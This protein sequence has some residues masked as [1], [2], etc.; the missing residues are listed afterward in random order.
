MTVIGRLPIFANFA[1]TKRGFDICS[2]RRPTKIEYFFFNKYN[3][4]DIK[5]E[6]LVCKNDD[7]C[8]DYD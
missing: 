8:R 3:L 6:Y 7:V 2:N 5:I 1:G 4:K